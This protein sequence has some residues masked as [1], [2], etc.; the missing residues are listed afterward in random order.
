MTRSTAPTT[1][2]I[3]RVRLGPPPSV[4]DGLGAGSVFVLALAA[5]APAAAP[6]AAAANAAFPAGARGFTTAAPAARLAPGGLRRAWLRS[7]HQQP[8]PRRP[9]PPPFGSTGA[10][11]PRLARSAVVRLGRGSELFGAH[12]AR[13]GAGLVRR[14]PR[15][16]PRLRRAAPAAPDREQP[17]PC[18]GR[19]H[20]GFRSCGGRRHRGPRLPALRRADRRALPPWARLAGVADTGR[21]GLARVADARGS[22]LAGVAD[23]W[24]CGLARSPTPQGWLCGGRPRR[25]RCGLARVTDRRGVGFAG[26]PTPAGWLCAGRPHRAFRPCAGRRRRPVGPCAGRRRRPDAGRDGS[27]PPGRPPPASCDPPGP[28]GSPLVFSSLKGPS[29][30]LGRDPPKIRS[31]PRLARKRVFEGASAPK[32]GGWKPPAWAQRYN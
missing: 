23:A 25:G 28:P 7:L 20:P 2:A 9:P 19:R 16:P 6:P 8:R 21:S 10:R 3:T 27:E 18:A 32:V 13:P 30:S 17:P 29:S 26:S 22:G 31:H 14:L 1:P 11:S 24:R 5:P 4:V 15:R 12:A